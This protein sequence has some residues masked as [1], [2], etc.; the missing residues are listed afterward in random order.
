MLA[1]YLLAITIL[2]SSASAAS[3]MTHAYL[4]ERW[5]AH[6]GNA[7]DDTYKRNF[8]I[9]TLFPDIRYMAK[10]ERAKT[11]KYGVSL[12]KIAYY[13]DAFAAGKQFHSYVD[14]TREGFVKK[15]GVL[16]KLPE[17]IQPNMRVGFLKILEDEIFCNQLDRKKIQ[18]YFYHID[19]AEYKFD[20]PSHIIQK[21]H[22]HLNHYFGRR[23]SLTCTVAGTVHLRFFS[24]TPQQLKQ[25]ST[26]LKK[27]AHHET[28]IDYTKKLTEIFDKKFKKV[29]IR[30]Q[31][32]TS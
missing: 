3:H 17:I 5:L 19:P 6:C 11:H 28:F 13:H 9:G 4:A 8:I 12:K 29:K 24:L 31:K 14:E 16:A 22:E 2:F 15:S 27:L 25:T 7:Y 10:I 23:P 1:R 18:N 20:I 30:P 21:W 32:A 26:L